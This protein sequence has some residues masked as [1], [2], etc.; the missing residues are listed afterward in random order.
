[1]GSVML[2]LLFLSTAFGG[3]SDVNWAR[4]GCG[5]QENARP[6]VAIGKQEHKPQPYGVDNK[7][8]IIVFITFVLQN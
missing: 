4:F 8:Y 5:W 7:K 3:G 6:L 2:L 1:M